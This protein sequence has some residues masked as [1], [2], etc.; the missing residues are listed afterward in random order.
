MSG[1]PEPFFCV[2]FTASDSLV[3]GLYKKKSTGFFLLELP[4]ADILS[5]FTGNI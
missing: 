1:S 4:L 5:N 3:N 2:F